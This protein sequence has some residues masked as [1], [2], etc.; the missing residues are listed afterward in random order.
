MD[1]GGKES[2]EQ[3]VLIVED[4]WLIA[5]DLV[6][7]VEAAGYRVIGPAHRVSNALPLVGNADVAILDV[8]LKNETSY[9][10]A[11]ALAELGIPFVFLTGYEHDQLVPEFRNAPLLNKPLQLHEFRSTLR[12]I[13]PA[14]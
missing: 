4:D 10:V 3:A 9:P 12:R 14:T 7:E 1:N 2:R 11:E 5:M 8:N 6:D 13:M